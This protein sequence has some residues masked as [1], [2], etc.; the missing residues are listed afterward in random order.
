MLRAI[1]V[2]ARTT[3][4]ASTAW[5]VPVGF[6]DFEDGTTQGWAGV[7]DAYLQVEAVGGGGPGSRLSVLTSRNGPRFY[8]QTTRQFRNRRACC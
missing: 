7:D 5:A 2:L 6:D 8:P 1:L 3:L 4:T